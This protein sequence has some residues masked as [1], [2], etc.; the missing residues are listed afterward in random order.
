MLALAQPRRHHA[1][2]MSRAG[3][4][5]QFIQLLHQLLFRLVC[6]KGFKSADSRKEAAGNV[7][8]RSTRN[9]AATAIVFR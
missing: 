9:R 5:C 1:A 8:W 4:A 7:W 2:R 3:P 6:L